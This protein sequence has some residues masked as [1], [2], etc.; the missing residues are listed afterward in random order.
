MVSLLPSDPV[1]PAFRDAVSGALTAF[2][3]AQ[4][5][6]LATM[7]P[8]TAPLLTRA[9]LFTTGGKRLRPA[10]CAWA[11]A[12]VADDL[13]LPDAVVR[14][15]SSLDLLHVSALVH[16]DVMDASDHRRGVPAAHRQ[17]EADHR[18]A[19]WRGDPAQFGRAGAILLG[20]LLLMWSV[21]MFRS[22]GLAPAALDRAQPY[23]EHA[24]AEVTAGQYLDVLAQAHDPHALT[25]TP[26]A[27]RGLSD[28]IATV[29]TWKSASYTIRR[30]LHIGAAIAGASDAQLE[31]LTAFGQPLGRAFQYRDDMLGIYGDAALTGKDSGEDLRVG[32]L[33]LIAAEAF[34]RASRAEAA[35]LAELFGDPG[36]S[37][38]QVERARQIIDTSGARDAV[39]QE[40]HREYD[41]ALA[42]LADADLT[43]A[44]RA[45][46]ARLARLA[47]RRDF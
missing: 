22:S 30:P 20:D 5:A 21:E 24:R 34:G 1:S 29:V 32:K 12:A 17:F 41:A 42:A 16:D 40:I 28:L 46:L 9:R 3:D 25:R 33:T 45:G 47:V 23:L 26:E 39:E 37:L 14:A 31:A 43:D 27:R 36:L 19:G 18:A 2:L 44:G 7:H 15:A 11:Y 10:F 6:P 8:L 38:P 4:D 13:R 35:E